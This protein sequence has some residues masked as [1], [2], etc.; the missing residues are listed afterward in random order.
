QLKE[1]IKGQPAEVIITTIHKF[2]DLGG[3]TDP[4]DNVIILID[5]AHRTEYGEFQSE[6]KA[7]LPNAKRFAFTGTPIPKTHREFG[8][9]KDGKLESYIDRYSIE[10]SIIDGATVRVRYTLGPVELQLDR[11]KLKQGYAEITADLDEEEK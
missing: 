4:R 8:A 6:L 3:L 7:A 5:E 1:K 11:E 9:V 10:D 2:R